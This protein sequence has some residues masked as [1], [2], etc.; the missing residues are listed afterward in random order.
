MKIINSTVVHQMHY[1]CDRTV[2]SRTHCVCVCVR[3]CVCACVCGVCVSSIRCTILHTTVSGFAGRYGCCCYLLHWG[4]I[5]VHVDSMVHIKMSLC[6]CRLGATCNHNAALLFKIDY[7]CQH[8][9]TQGSNRPCTS[10]E[11]KWMSPALV[12]LEPVKASDMTVENPRWRFNTTRIA[13]MEQSAVA[14][15]VFHW[16]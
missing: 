15:S 11:N 10:M 2:C 16:M 6:C 12:N 5:D 9:L 1:G 7:A 13:V 8:G 14:F 3:V 4:G